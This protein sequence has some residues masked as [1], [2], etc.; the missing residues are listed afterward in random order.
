MSFLVIQW[1]QQMTTESP[2][3]SLCFRTAMADH[4]RL[5]AFADK[6]QRG[7]LPLL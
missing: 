3:Q 2:G 5:L 7:Y 1:T 6:V 4:R